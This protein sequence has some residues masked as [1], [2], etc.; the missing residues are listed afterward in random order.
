MSRL[1]LETH[2]NRTAF[3]PGETIQG[4]TGW[5]LDAP[6]ERVELCLLWHTAGKGDR[7]TNVAERVTFESPAAVDAQT[8]SLTA[9]EGP[10]SY[11]GKLITLSWALELIVEPGGH[12]ERLELVIAP[13]ADTVTTRAAH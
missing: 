8:F 12:V 2:E 6:P 1:Q 11:E 4:V 5:E 9:P 3:V 10:Y 7:D 13:D